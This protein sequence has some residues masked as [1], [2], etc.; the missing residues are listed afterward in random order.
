MQA[1]G[2]GL[3]TLLWV[4]GLWGAVAAWEAHH[5]RSLWQKAS[6]SAWI[7]HSL[8]LLGTVGLLLYTLLAHRYEFHYAWAHGSRLLPVEYITAA[9]WEGQEGSFLL[10]MIW[11]VVFGWA[12]LAIRDE[13]RW[14]LLAGL[15]A[16]NGYL[17]TF[18][19]G[20]SLPKWSI[21]VGGVMLWT[22]WAAR[23][24]PTAYRLIGVGL[25]LSGM[26]IDLWWVKV[27]IVAFAL[28]LMGGGKI[29]FLSTA[30]IIALVSL[31]L[32]TTWGSFP[33]LY[34]WEVRG[35]VPPGFIPTDG[36]GL[37]PLLQSF[38]MVIHPPVLFS[39]YAAAALPFWE[40][41]LILRSG[42]LTTTS[43]R[44]LLRWIW[45]TVGLL[46]LGIGLGAYW[47]YETLNFGGYW[48]WD[49]VENASLAPWL[50]LVAAAH[51]LWVWRRQR[52][53]SGLALTLTLLGFPMVLYSSYLTRSGVLSDSSVH[54]FTD[55][56]LGSWLLWGVGLSLLGIGVMGIRAL[57]RSQPKLTDTRPIMQSALT[58]GAALLVWIA[59]VLIVFTSLP[60]INKIL[61]T[62]WTL[63]SGA[64][65]VYYEWI[66][67]FTVP[68]LGLMGYA[69]VRAYKVKGWER[70]LWGSALALGLIVLVLWW[71]GW[72]FVYHTTYRNL[73][74][75]SSWTARARGAIFLLLDDL[76]WGGAL[77]SGGA[78][79]AV[80]FR[81]LRG[82]H[83]WAVI[84]HIGFAMMIIGALLSSGYEK[85]ISQN[86]NP[87][88][89]STSDNLF[90]PRG[91]SSVALGYFVRYDGLVEPLPPIRSVTPLLHE[92]GQTLWRFRDSLG[93]FYQ[94]WL[95]EGLLSQGELIRS[96]ALPSA[97]S[98]IESNLALLPTEPADRRY[99][100]RVS[101]TT[102]DSTQTYPLLLEADVSESS[103]LLAHP[104][105]VRLWH[106]DLY[107]HITSLP[108]AEGSP[109]AQATLAFGIKD[110]ASFE[111]VVMVFE[112]LTEVE[113][114]PHP[115]FRA[116][117]AAWKGL[118]ELV[119]RFSVD[120]SIREKELLTPIATLP[121]LGLSVQLES[122]SVKAG[123]LNFRV[124][125]RRRPD[126]FI[127][128]K[129]LYKPFIG[130]FWMG[131]LLTLVGA[132]GAMLRHRQINHSI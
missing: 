27:G 66:G 120:F 20:V 58:G 40:G 123:K 90:I 117:F 29:P 128:V 107:V 82:T 132:F 65:Q 89:P 116:W 98:F 105:H 42:K 53:A 28:I 127:T 103:G 129:I 26:I 60:A 62:N 15:L 104:A 33:F 95:P 1:V 75:S 9:L 106:G 83:I 17:A 35:D 19:L 71:A 131:I 111:D 48:N 25:L 36:N 45:L 70:I 85:V 41:L 86:L 108:K 79:L 87:R 31:P 57:R 119:Q 78:A 63:G 56:G 8:A 99:R 50:V 115:T 30:A 100:Y 84:A 47:A 38:W 6:W 43:S 55:L 23:D 13:N 121:A 2:A 39:G 81:K 73:L 96:V 113:N 109:L 77:V 5:K 130:L 76:L 102:L 118:P 46:G 88:S 97:S 110:T 22:V 7:I 122:V 80:W 10:W 61:G 21:I 69:L 91:G 64:L 54:S 126:A 3:I 51:M 125:V 12:I 72:D 14:A 114:A 49:P 101:L 18:L 74:S 32:G 93:F 59:L 37:N 34:L 92:K 16:T 67:V 94:V 11:H 24:L 52:K 112:R 124:A 44:R 4:S 68:L